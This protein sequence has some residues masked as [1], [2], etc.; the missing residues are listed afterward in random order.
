LHDEIGQQLTGLKMPLELG[1]PE[2]NNRAQAI[3]EE[4][5]TR[6]CY[7]SV[8][9]RPLALDDLGLVLAVRSQIERYAER[10]G[11]HVALLT[12]GVDA[13][14]RR[15]VEVAAFRIVQEAITNVAR[16]AGVGVA[17]VRL[18]LDGGLLHVTIADDGSG[19]TRTLAAPPMGA[20]STGVSGMAERAAAVGGELTFASSPGAGTAVS[21]VIP[22]PPAP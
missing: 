11:V 12:E 19:T 18:A 8:D 13:R 15:D 6:V 21:A 10:T 16:H 22:V 7:L 5:M 2:A 4:L 17:N 20:P 9:L 3:S 1:T 14:M